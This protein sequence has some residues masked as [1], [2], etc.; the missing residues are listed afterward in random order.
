MSNPQE[1]KLL[2][3]EPTMS[4]VFAAHFQQDEKA[5]QRPAKPASEMYTGRVFDQFFD[6]EGVSPVEREAAL[7]YAALQRLIAVQLLQ[8]M[9]EQSLTRSEMARR[10][11]T[12]RAQ[13]DKLLDADCD[14]VTLK[15]LSRAAA[16]VGRRM[17]VELI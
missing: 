5:E 9:E 7:K 4:P 17:R 13:L 14:R 8:A 2:D 1:N 12:S 3:E 10:M 16:A 11:S 6:E 15:T